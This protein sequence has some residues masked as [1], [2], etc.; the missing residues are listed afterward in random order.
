[1]NNRQQGWLR[2]AGLAAGVSLMLGAC[3]DKAQIDPSKQ[4]GANPTLPGAKGF[5]V[6]PM[7]VPEGGGW[8]GNTMPKVAFGLKIEKIASGL[9]HPRQVLVLPNEDILLVESNGPGEEAVTTPK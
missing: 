6:P 7:Q 2:A 9:K 1:M 3:S 5:L 8:Q 4:L